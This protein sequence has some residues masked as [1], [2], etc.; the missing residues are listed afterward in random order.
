MIENTTFPHPETAHNQL[1]KWATYASVATASIIII[2]KI[3]GWMMTGSLTLLASLVDSILDML[4]SVINLV[5][6]R[7]AL[8]PPDKEHRFG[9]GKAEDLASFIQSGFIAFSALFIAVEAAKRFYAPQAPENT[10]IGI[11]II[12]FSTIITLGLVLFQRYVI[13]KTNSSVI[14]ADNIHYVSDIFVNLA[15]I[16]SLFAGNFFTN[17]WI[18][19]VCAIFIALYMLQG[20]RSI[21]Q[22]AFNNLMDHE[23]SGEDRKK[24]YAIIHA[25][26]EVLGVHEMKTRSSGNKPFIQ[27]HLEMDGSI[28]LF[29]AHSISDEIEAA[30]KKQ[31]PNADIFIHQDPRKV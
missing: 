27:F 5:A 6:V 7:Y 28:S 22:K 18:D 16:A 30:I 25:H 17:Y 20:A 24:V 12:L 15:I 8:Q 19:P 2:A 13:R 23:F 31:F 4:I 11:A 10:T 26:P 1:T 14:A 9:H 29:N 21:V 3:I